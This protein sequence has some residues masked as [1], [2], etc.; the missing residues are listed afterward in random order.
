MQRRP[1]AAGTSRMTD[2][3]LKNRNL[4]GDIV[5]VFAVLLALYVA[6]LVRDVLLLLYV[7]ALFA[8]VFKPVVNAVAGV[9][10]GRWQ[11]F[12]KI[13]ILV[14]LLGVAAVFA[15]FIAIAVPPVVHDLQEFSR[16][17]PSRTPVI[18]DEL[19]H[20]PF[21]D[22]IDSREIYTR[23]RDLASSA[24]KYILV[25]V[26]SWAGKLASVVMGVVLTIYFLT[27]GDTAY[28]WFLSF[29]P[30]DSRQRL[31]LTL[32]RADVRMGKW[33]LGQGSLMLILWLTST[34]VYLA[35]H[36]R[37]AYALGALAGILNIIPIIGAVISISLALIVAAIDSW[38]SVAGVAIF[39]A[40]YQQ[41]ENSYLTPRIMK[42]SVGL[43]G[44]AVLVSL[45][46]GT[47]LAGIVGAMVAVPTA[48]LVGELVDEY[49]AKKNST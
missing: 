38:G 39:Y 6:W 29:F 48:V 32:Q 34:I 46:L 8:V 3:T 2:Y 24:A 1:G 47:E 16:E 33:L 4:R 23:A 41:V 21:A 20:I 35:L 18:L 45:L 42:N 27:E 9:R 17:A 26:T 14:L 10:I 36:V 22:Q 12:R 30:V 49:L 5:F 28:R 25:S 19:R 43:P 13:A 15:A 37:Y 40:I 44:L 31:D 11:P 7:S